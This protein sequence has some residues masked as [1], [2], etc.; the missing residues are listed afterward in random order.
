MNKEKQIEEM[1]KIL[2]SN[3]GD[4]SKCDCFHRDIN[5]IDACYFKYAE[6]IYNAGYRKQSEGEWK[7]DGYLKNC[8]ECGNCVNFNIV[9]SWL[10]NFCPYCGAKMKGERYEN[11]T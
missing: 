3:C 7:G 6:M 9:S 1:A 5:G 10:Y 2:A 8:S 11:Q 4:C